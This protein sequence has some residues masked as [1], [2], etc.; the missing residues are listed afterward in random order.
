MKP[1]SLA[2]AMLVG[3]SSCF[4]QDIH[5]AA[6]NGDVETV[7]ILLQQ[8]H[9]LINNR[10][11][12]KNY[13]LLHSAFIGENVDLI[14][15]LINE[16]ADV[17]AKDSENYSVL[18][19][20]C[21]YGMTEIVSILIDKGAE[22]QNDFNVFGTH[23]VHFSAYNGY[24]D[25]TKLLLQNGADVNIPN[26]WGITPLHFAAYRDNASMI[27]FLIEN[28]AE[29]NTRDLL[30]GFTPLHNAVSS[31]QMENTQLLIN[32]GA[33][34]K[35]KDNNDKTVLWAPIE[36]GDNELLKYLLT[37]YEDVNEKENYLEYTPL[38]RAAINGYE[39]IVKLLLLNGAD[40][41]AVDKLGN[42][43]IDYA[44]KYYHPLVIEKLYDAGAESLVNISYDS[45]V[46]KINFGDAS[47]VYLGRSGWCV[48]TETKMLIFD[49]YQE[50]PLPAK[51]SL[52]NGHITV[53]ELKNKN[54]Y[55]FIS[56]VHRDHYDKVI[57]EWE[58]EIENIHFVFGWKAHDNPNYTYMSP[59]KT[60]AL[61]GMEITRVNSPELGDLL[62]NFLVKVDGITLFHS[63][64]PV[65]N[66]TYRHDLEY[67][68]ETAGNV[69]LMFFCADN[70]NAFELP[71]F[72][73]EKI[74]PQYFFPMHVE[75]GNEN[76]YSMFRDTA[77]VKTNSTIITEP[78]NRGDKFLLNKKNTKRYLPD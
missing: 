31:S 54:V 41:N 7:K 15:H 30:N 76:I 4:A 55:V 3:L 42:K 47:I 9:L 13:S 11:K 12:E 61:D 46:D 43:P 34:Y 78:Y 60:I 58:K 65:D 64:D 32:N 18:N 72:A 73:I 29:R 17:N 77:L 50:A 8:N 67:L 56:H 16:G 19:R 48:E 36:K 52:R 57:H 40:V 45:E 37:L 28:G 20:A 71:L 49:Y 33:D 23:P 27:K 5:E 6:K 70:P 2:L 25:I 44:I 26:K 21:V 66:E 53:S 59:R 63:G 51:P 68:A 1:L 14:K 74:Q 75:R 24:V 69:D 39:Q 38:H 35:I 10:S 22:V 62:G